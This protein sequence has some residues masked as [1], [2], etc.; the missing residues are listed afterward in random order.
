V[1]TRSS[2]AV[3]A[4]FVNHLALKLP[5]RFLGGPDGASPRRPTIDP[6]DPPGAGRT[7]RSENP[8]M[9]QQ[10][11]PCPTLAKPI[12]VKVPLPPA[13]V[14]VA[15]PQSNDDWF[16]AKKRKRTV[17]C[18]QCDAC[19]RDDCGTCLNCLD[20]PKFGGSGA[21]SADGRC[22]RVSAR[23]AERGGRLTARP[24]GPSQGQG[25][26]GRPLVPGTRSSVGP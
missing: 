8:M 10:C 18:G 16:S 9:M 22:A 24:N 12:S 13:L 17:A 7:K 14:E 26:A 15:T 6:T 11:M 1:Q 19:C 25:P 5:K 3:S 2:K 23:R 21:R 20:K 4:I